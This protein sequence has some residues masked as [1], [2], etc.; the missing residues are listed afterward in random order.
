MELVTNIGFGINGAGS[1]QVVGS[2]EYKISKWVS[3]LKSGVCSVW[4]CEKNMY[5]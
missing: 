1:E 2:S 3:G 5:I 4:R